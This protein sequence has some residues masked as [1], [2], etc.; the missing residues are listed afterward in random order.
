MHIHRRAPPR[1]RPDPR[2]RKGGARVG[3]WG[4]QSNLLATLIQTG[5]IATTRLADCQGLERTTLT[6]DSGMLVR[7]G[8]VRIDEGED[9]RVRKAAMTPAG[10]GGASGLPLWKKAQDAALEAAAQS[11]ES[12]QLKFSLIGVA[13]LNG[14]T[15]MLEILSTIALAASAQS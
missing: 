2:L 1:S 8:F 7:D 4:A 3:R 6:R 14:R 11:Q 13:T 9:R 5:P 12:R 15:R 10:R